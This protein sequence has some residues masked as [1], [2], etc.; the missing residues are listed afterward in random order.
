MR[1]DI[2][3]LFPDMFSPLEM[4][5]VG[6]ARSRSL[7]D[8]HV[9]DIREYTHDRHRS[10]DDEPFGGGG[11]MVMKPEPIFEAF[12]A[13][14]EDSP[15]PVS[16]VLLMSPG[17]TP[18]SQAMAE[19]LAKE[20]RLVLICGHY[21]GIDERVALHLATDEI[22]IGDYVLTGG[23]LPAM[24]VVDAVA[25]LVPGVLGCETSAAQDSF[26]MGILEHPHYT[27]PREYRGMSVP[28]V[29]LSGDHERIRLWRRK[30]ALKKTMQRRP[31]LIDEAK[32]SDE[33][34][35]LIEQL[36]RE[37]AETL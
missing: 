19:S 22:S 1:I 31:D 37:A 3:T 2:L 29:L 24:V 21:E 30:E 14:T 5:I 26:S 23:E 34:R 10:A 25:R 17:G 15:I 9:W 13:V 20:Q 28:D 6:R 4:S 27:R 11:G 33:D 7:I 36:R 8:V 18:F 35:Q 32:L 16:R 12:D